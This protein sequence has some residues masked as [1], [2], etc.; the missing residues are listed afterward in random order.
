MEDRFSEHYVTKSGVRW[1]PSDYKGLDQTPYLAYLEK[2]EDKVRQYQ[3]EQ[4]T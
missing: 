3:R 1:A 4:T 2:E